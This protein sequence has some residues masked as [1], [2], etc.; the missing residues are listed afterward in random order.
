MANSTLVDNGRMT[1]KS[2]DF[3]SS[4]NVKNITPM[5]KFSSVSECFLSTK[6]GN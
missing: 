3:N 5:V 2:L 1:S 4:L 6:K